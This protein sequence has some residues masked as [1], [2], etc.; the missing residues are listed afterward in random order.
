MRSEQNSIGK[1]VHAIRPKSILRLADGVCWHARPDARQVSLSV[2]NRLLRNVSMSF[3]PLNN[4][5]KFT[6]KI[7]KLWQRLRSRKS[8]IDT[9]THTPKVNGWRSLVLRQHTDSIIIIRSCFRHLFN[10]FVLYF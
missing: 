5:S 1:H 9:K 10:I 8:S 7:N 3:N 2:L 6:V 4:D